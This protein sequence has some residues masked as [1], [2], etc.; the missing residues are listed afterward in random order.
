MLFAQQA[1]GRSVD[2]PPHVVFTPMVSI[3]TNLLLLIF[4]VLW[5]LFLPC[6]ILLLFTLVGSV[7][8][9][10]LLLAFVVALLIPFVCNGAELGFQ[11]KLALERIEGGNHH[12]N[13]LIVWGSGYPHSL[14]LEPV[15]LALG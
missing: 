13:F 3:L 4:T 1:I 10:L 12:Q 2:S 15:E 9:I 7:L 8:L 5:W 14:C 6:L 11:L